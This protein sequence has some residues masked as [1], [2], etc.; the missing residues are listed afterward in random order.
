MALLTSLTA[1]FEGW[2]QQVR[3]GAVGFGGVAGTDPYNPTAMGGTVAAVGIVEG[4]IA[5]NMN[6]ET[7]QTFASQMRFVY[8]EH[9]TRMNPQLTLNIRQISL[10]NIALGLSMGDAAVAAGTTL[11][12]DAAYLNQAENNVTVNHAGFMCCELFTD[13]PPDTDLGNGGTLS[14][15]LWKVKVFG[16]GEITFAGDAHTEIPI[17]VQA[18]GNDSDKIGQIVSSISHTNPNYDQ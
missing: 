12:M 13:S 16:N 8:D 9:V 3:G 7:I 5:F 6:Q 2:R 11:N 10:Y 17:R 15:Q 14:M 18:F 1:G 4:P